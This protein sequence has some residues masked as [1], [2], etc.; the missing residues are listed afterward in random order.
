MENPLVEPILMDAASLIA[1]TSNVSDDSEFDEHLHKTVPA[2]MNKIVDI[3]MK[4]LGDEVTFSAIHSHLG[5]VGRF[6]G[7]GLHLLIQTLIKF[8]G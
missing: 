8:L 7:E 2:P 4:H 5:L 6:H 3:M 1:A